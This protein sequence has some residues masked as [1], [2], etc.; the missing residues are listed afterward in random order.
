[1]RLAVCAFVFGMAVGCG[2]VDQTQDSATRYLVSGP[3]SAGVTWKVHQQKIRICYS[4]PTS[5][6]THREEVVDAVHK[7]MRPIAEIAEE[8]VAAVVEL[9]AI[10]AACDVKVYIG[11][12]SPAQTQMGS[13]PIV[14]LNHSGWYGSQTVTL[15][16]FGHAFGLLD[17]YNGRG[18]SCQTGQP[19]SVMCRARYDDLMPDDVAGIQ[20]MY[21]RVRDARGVVTPDEYEGKVVY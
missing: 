1:M 5:G 3:A 19:D 14:Y 17:T 6:D 18:G 2:R 8:P 20:D 10:G 15:H 13:R 12:Y 21:Q 16:E 11:S 9:V 7:W 4:G